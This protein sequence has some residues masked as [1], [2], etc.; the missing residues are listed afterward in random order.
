MDERTLMK[1]PS[2]F[3]LTRDYC[4]A[5]VAHLGRLALASDVG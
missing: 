5:L 2:D 1:K 4:R 3:E